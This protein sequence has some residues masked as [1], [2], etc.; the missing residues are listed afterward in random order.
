[1]K[2][3]LSIFLFCLLAIGTRA[4]TLH[5]AVTTT[6]WATNTD[7]LILSTNVLAGSSL[8]QRN[9]T[10]SNFLDI[11]K[12]FNNWPAGGGDRQYGNLS[13]TNFSSLGDPGADT[14]V[15][16]DDSAGRYTNLTIG[17]GLAIT[18]TE[19]AATG[20]GGGEANVNGEVSV[21]NAT[22]I[23][24]VNG[25][26]GVTNL[27]RSIQGG[28]G[29]VL[30]NQGTNVMAAID[31][32]VVAVA[33]M[34]NSW[35]TLADNT[36]MT[37]ALSARILANFTGLEWVTNRVAAALT[38]NHSVAVNLVST[39][40]NAGMIATSL[41]VNLATTNSGPVTMSGGLT[42]SGPTLL[43]GAVRLSDSAFVGTD[44]V[45][46]RNG[47]NSDL[48]TATLSVSSSSNL[49]GIHNIT[50]AGTNTATAFVASGGPGSLQTDNGYFN[51]NVHA[52][53]VTVSNVTA[54]RV[55]M[56]N[57]SKNLTN[58]PT[59]TLFNLAAN[60]YV[61]YTNALTKTSETV[62]GAG[63]GNTNYLLT[64]S[65]NAANKFYLGSSNVHIYAISGSTL[66]SPISW[67]AVVTN[68]SAST[69]GINFS[70]G[71]NRLRFKGVY[72]TNAPSVLTNNT[73]LWLAGECDG[74]NT[75]VGYT[76][77]APGL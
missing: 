1:M 40:T 11:L 2:T 23:G 17:A 32:A 19:L 41:R 29:I 13:L 36:T 14:I 60:P 31:P 3:T 70:S 25:K 76:Y 18:G 20:G 6:T 35:L 72:G 54:S 47:A 22:R 28:N 51:T 34:T 9:I 55:A 66:G 30:T 74:T 27:L 26:S 75:V 58:E 50:S 71:T 48:M 64:L 45:I 10:L 7:W 12:G 52:A 67:R 5:S 46:K 37:Q 73:A 59:A 21:T 53:A 38:N 57:G 65:T 15:F 69:W 33:G 39:L 61:A 44:T 62:S 49:T 43:Q 16:W 77:Y 42:N 4:D 68:L 63:N 56:Y 24:L 8:K